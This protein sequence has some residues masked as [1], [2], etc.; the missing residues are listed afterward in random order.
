M[1][2]NPSAFVAVMLAGGIFLGVGAVMFYAMS[3]RGVG[4][5]KQPEKNPEGDDVTTLVPASVLRHAVRPM[6]SY[7]LE[8][9][10]DWEAQID[11]AQSKA[12]GECIEDP[13]CRTFADAVLTALEVIFPDEGDFAATTSR[14]PW[15]QRARARVEA[16]L[17]REL[18]PTEAE[19]RARLCA[20]VGVRALES[21]QRFD[22]AVLCM[23]QEAWPNCDWTQGPHR[24]WSFAAREWCTRVLSAHLE[25]NTSAAPT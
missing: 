2:R 11:E 18:G 7:S 10:Y 19:V 24:P 13:E 5:S 4:S 6:P 23:L 1:R 16:V 14:S 21:G 3:R 25:S 17:R 12:V 20:P 8:P 9:E 22:R 15:K